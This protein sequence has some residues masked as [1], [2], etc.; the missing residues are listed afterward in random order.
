MVVSNIIFAVYRILYKSLAIDNLNNTAAKG[1]IAILQVETLLLNTIYNPYNILEINK[2]SKAFATEQS[3][4]TS[5]RSMS[6]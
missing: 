6:A 2:T 3:I 1:C 4:D 5:D